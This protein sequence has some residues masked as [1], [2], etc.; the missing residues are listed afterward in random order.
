MMKAS[1]VLIIII[2]AI[3]GLHA[4]RLM[5][6][7]G[8]AKEKIPPSLAVKQIWGINGKDSTK[9]AIKDGV[10]ILQLNSVPYK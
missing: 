9:Q 7:T 10:F 8:V 6:R 5:K 2:T 4:R 1:W 3:S